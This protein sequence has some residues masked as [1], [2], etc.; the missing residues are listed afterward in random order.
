[1][2]TAHFLCRGKFGVVYRCSEKT[3]SRPVAIKV[4]KS[5]HNKKD[6]VEKEVSIMKEFNHPNLLQFIEF[7]ADKSSYILVTEL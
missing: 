3:T 7:V 1:M 4:M 2:Q 6:D 5:R